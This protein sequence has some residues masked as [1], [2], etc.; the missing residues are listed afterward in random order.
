[1][2]I[3]AKNTKED[4][5]INHGEEDTVDTFDWVYGTYT[6][7]SSSIFKSKTSAETYKTN[8]LNNLGEPHIVDFEE[9]DL[10][11]DEFALVDSIIDYTKDFV[12]GDTMKINSEDPRIKE[13]LEQYID[14]TNLYHKLKPWCKSAIGRGVGYLEMSGVFDKDTPIRVKNIDARSMY[15]VLDDAGEIEGYN[16]YYGTSYA[17]INKEDVVN[18]KKEEI[19]ALHV[20]KKDSEAY[21]RG[22]IRPSR[23]VIQNFLSSQTEL[24]KLLIRKANSPI[25]FRLGSPD[26]KKNPPKE[27]IKEFGKK[28]KKMTNETE[29]VT[30]FNVDSKVLEFGNLGEKFDKIIDNDFLLL[31]SSFK[32]PEVLVGKSN[33]P[34]GLADEQRKAWDKHINSIQQDIEKLLQEKLFK[35]VLDRHNLKGHYN[36]IW[37]EQGLD[38]NLEMA[39]KI[40]LI[41]QNQNLSSPLR[42]SLEKQMADILGFDIAEDLNMDAEG[43]DEREKERE[44]E[45]TK[46]LPKLP[47]DHNLYLRGTYKHFENHEE[48]IS[49]DLLDVPL[50][51][52]VDTSLVDLRTEISNVIKSDE[53][54]LLKANNKIEVSAGYL[55]K[56]DILR[57]K[58]ELDYA[59]QNDLSIRELEKNLHDKK[60]IK[61][62]HPYDVHGVDK[63]RTVLNAQKRANLVA[64]TE[65][66][67]IANLAAKNDY[68]KKGVKEVRW[69]A[70]ITDRTCDECMSLDGTVMDANNPHSMPPLHCNCRCSLSPVV[71]LDSD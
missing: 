20:K 54:K 44:K 29:F 56:R 57:L 32:I 70:G 45:E 49:E 67:R 43:P 19:M 35:Y 58:E 4:Y 38:E 3:F 26:L 66:I 52:W 6:T 41:L 59:F 25:H 60:I 27:V 15:I 37:T 17:R 16:Q 51:E 21:G 5:V 12:L 8:I 7:E 69:T 42:L 53:F 62:L 63:T 55:N 31:C 61:E 50:T 48:Q 30:G 64:R 9:I 33:I 18:F 1:M 10:I 40:S 68:L 34:E 13:V 22:M 36:I 2:G 47:E 46:P 23:Q 71:S 39:Q 11:M 65:T 24:H 28:A 14:E